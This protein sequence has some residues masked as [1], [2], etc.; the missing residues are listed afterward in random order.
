MIDDN[1]FFLQN[2]S[3]F[4]MYQTLFWNVSYNLLLKTQTM[5]SW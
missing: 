2:F 4:L 1:A 3:W 5:K